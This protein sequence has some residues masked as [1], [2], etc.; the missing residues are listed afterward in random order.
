[1]REEVCRDRVEKTEFDTV[2][3]PKKVKKSQKAKNPKRSYK[4][5]D[6]DNPNMATTSAPEDFI[7]RNSAPTTLDIPTASPPH[8]FPAKNKPTGNEKIL[9]F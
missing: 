7:A 1:M 4:F 8:K 5:P 6:N 9:S 3:V 2:T